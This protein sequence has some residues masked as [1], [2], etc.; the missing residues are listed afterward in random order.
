MKLG[1]K[2]NVF[3]ICVWLVAIVMSVV[4]YFL[5]GQITKFSL[6]LDIV[7]GFFVGMSTKELI[8]WVTEE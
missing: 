5:T 1:V 6:C 2:F 3:L 8:E 7:G 4:N